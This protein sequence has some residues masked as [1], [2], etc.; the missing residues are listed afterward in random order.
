M[1][2]AVAPSELAEA[3]AGFQYAYLLTVSDGGRAHAVAAQPQWADGRFTL[4]KLGNRSRRNAAARP[5]V[6]LLWPPQDV[7]GYSLIVDGD[8]TLA[9]A[10]LT[11]TPSRA[12]LHR[13]GPSPVAASSCTSDC[14]E[15]PLE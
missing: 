1:S 6:T 13:P 15:L 9:D 10:V 5:A 7:A 4:G 12:G 8:A 11:I 2:I 3:V 14:R